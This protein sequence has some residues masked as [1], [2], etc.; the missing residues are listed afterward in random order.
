LYRYALVIWLG[1]GQFFDTWFPPL[2]VFD[3][4]RPFKAW[5]HRSVLMTLASYMIIRQTGL[6]AIFC[7]ALTC[8]EYWSSRKRFVAFRVEVYDQASP[9]LTFP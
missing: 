1:S 2:A 7:L 6:H 4:L 9:T 8:R 3:V 5:Y